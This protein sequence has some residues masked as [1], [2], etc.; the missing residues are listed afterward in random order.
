M[1]TDGGY[2]GNEELWAV[3]MMNDVLLSPEWKS[4]REDEKKY[5]FYSVA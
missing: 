1:D 4:S 3:D 2:H 5:S